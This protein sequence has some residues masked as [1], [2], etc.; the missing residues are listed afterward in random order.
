[1]LGSLLWGTYRITEESFTSGRFYLANLTC[2]A[3]VPTAKL[4]AKPKNPRT[5][6]QSKRTVITIVTKHF[7]SLYISSSNV[8]ET[9]LIQ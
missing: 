6:S 3:S 7:M 9:E 1:M 5:V 8:S 2:N 4:T